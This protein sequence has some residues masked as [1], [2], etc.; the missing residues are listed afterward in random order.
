MS[1][2]QDPI[3]ELNEVLNWLSNQNHRHQTKKEESMR[4]PCLIGFILATGFTAP[5]VDSA[6]FTLHE[7]GTFTSISG[8]DGVLLPGLE[9]EEEALPAFVQSHEGMASQSQLSFG[10]KGW[11][12]PLHN[13]TIK[14]ET[15]VIYFYTSQ[16]FAAHVHVGFN[17]GSI[18]QWFPA[19]SG[20]ETPPSR[21]TNAQGAP[22]GGDID[23]AKGFQGDI[24]WD[25]HPT[26]RGRGQMTDGHG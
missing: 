4:L 20:G 13:V 24:Q 6:G 18:S 14:M 22:I 10:G 16:P 25:H 2:F 15:P 23:F 1:H 7:W 26:G 3:T 9:R 12:R 17:G 21:F 19:R 5:A 11:L 8:S